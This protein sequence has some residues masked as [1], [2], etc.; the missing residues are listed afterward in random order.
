MSPLSTGK[1]RLRSEPWS[2]SLSNRQVLPPQGKADPGP[3]QGGDKVLFQHKELLGGKGDGGGP[4]S[5]TGWPRHPVP[6]VPNIPARDVGFS[7]R[8][9]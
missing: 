1:G 3:H 2:P 4:S 9:S 5:T 8:L 7:S 6:E